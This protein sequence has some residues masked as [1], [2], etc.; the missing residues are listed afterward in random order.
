[1][2]TCY[3][4]EGHVNDNVVSACDSIA[5]FEGSIIPNNSDNDRHFNHGTT[6]APQGAKYYS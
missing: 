4:G 2:R 1:M 5:Q 3:L 6:M